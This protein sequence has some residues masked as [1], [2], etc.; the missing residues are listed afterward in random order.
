MRR[1]V[2][3][4]TGNGSL[5]PRNCEYGIGVAMLFTIPQTAHASLAEHA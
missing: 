1:G 5:L 2:F 3:P 4:S